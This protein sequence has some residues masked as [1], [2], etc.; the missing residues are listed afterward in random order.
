MRRSR[1][2]HQWTVVV[3]L[4]TC[5]SDLLT[6]NMNL[7]HKPAAGKRRHLYANGLPSLRLEPLGLLHIASK[8]RG[9]LYTLPER[10]G[11]EVV[12]TARRWGKKGEG[13]AVPED[14]RMRG[15]EV[16]QCQ[17]MGDAAES[18]EY[19][20]NKNASVFM[21]SWRHSCITSADIVQWCGHVTSICRLVLFVLI[22][23]T[24][25]T[26]PFKCLRLLSYKIDS[27]RPSY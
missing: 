6:A 21:H 18:D 5:S 26:Q 1:A 4:C 3:R 14:G 15:E 12:Y 11:G 27:C 25:F 8:M 20:S 19:G 24:S 23:V 22:T 13:A 16:L 9:G 2:S 17:K 7:S 10:W